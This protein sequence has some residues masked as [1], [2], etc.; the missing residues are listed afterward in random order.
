MSP[1]EFEKN[2]VYCPEIT[3]DMSESIVDHETAVRIALSDCTVDW[4]DV[5]CNLMLSNTDTTLYSTA[6]YNPICETFVCPCCGTHYIADSAGFIPNC[7][8]CGSTM[9]KEVQI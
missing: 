1:E 7:K 6:P 2:I 8:N 9:V 3:E 4:C 5:K